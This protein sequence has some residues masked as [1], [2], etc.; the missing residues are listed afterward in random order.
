MNLYNSLGCLAFRGRRPARMKFSSFT[1]CGVPY[2]P[3]MLTTTCVSNISNGLTL[4][5]AS[6]YS[7]PFRPSPAYW[8]KYTLCPPTKFLNIFPIYHRT[9]LC[10]TPRK[11]W[12]RVN[13][14]AI[15]QTPKVLYHNHVA[16]SRLVFTC[17]SV[18]L[19]AP[20]RGEYYLNISIHYYLKKTCQ[21]QASVI[22]L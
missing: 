22:I 17:Y 1:T 16:D 20:P 8:R 10:Q 4:P 5:L 14:Y 19:P 7:A 15:R 18:T 11:L 12:P 3:P 9:N 21:T 6:L 2:R 13:Y